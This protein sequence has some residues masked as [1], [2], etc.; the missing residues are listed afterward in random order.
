MIKVLMVEDN[1]GDARMVHDQIVSMD[2]TVRFD[3]TRV[4][5]LKEAIERLRERVFDAVLLDLG[6]PDAAG[7]DSIA[8]ITGPPH[9]GAQRS[10]R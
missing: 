6:L 1:H 4:T 10:L 2:G 7:L 8:P 5:R 3:L 9:R